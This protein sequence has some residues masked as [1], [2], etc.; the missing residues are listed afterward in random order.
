VGVVDGDTIT[1]LGAGSRQSHIRLQGIDALESRSAFGQDSKRNLSNLVFDRQIVVEYEKTDQ[2]GRIL[3][4]TR[5]PVNAAQ[6]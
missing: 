6:W 3:G 1:A 2:Y 4:T 5:L